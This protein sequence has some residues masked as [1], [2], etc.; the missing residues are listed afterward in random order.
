MAGQGGWYHGSAVSPLARLRIFIFCAESALERAME[1]QLAEVAAEAEAKLLA[2]RTLQELDE[3]RIAYLGRKG[4]LTLLVRQMGK[5]PADQRPAVG[6]AV[7]EVRDRLEQALARR[8]AALTNEAETARLTAEALDVTLPGRI[9]ALGHPHPVSLVTDEICAIFVG[10]GFEVVESPEVEWYEYNFEA[11]NYP[12]EHP[13][14]D[15]QDSFYVTDRI[16]LRTQ[17]SPAQIREMRRR[18]PAP[19]RIVVPGKVYRRENVTM[20]HSHTFHQF[21]GLLV[22]EGI[23][24]ADL[25]GTLEVFIHEYFGPDTQT[26]FRPDFFPFTEPSGD[27]S[28]SCSLCAGQGCAWCKHSGWIEL[29]GCGMVHPNVLRAGGY[30]PEKVSGWAFGFGIDRLAQRKYDIPH[31]RTLFENDMR[32]LRQF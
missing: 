2:A 18:Y 5:L 9:W 30:D 11:L 15:E 32:F 31:I 16:L 22:D 23:T 14:T 26:R 19:V 27:Y 1:R 25:R 24:F 12:P 21:E 29:A 6:R 4:K 17:T 3:V 20:T 10:L 8:R 7:N 28:I 13:A